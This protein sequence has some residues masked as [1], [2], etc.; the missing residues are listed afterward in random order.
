MNMVPD[1]G[2][3]KEGCEILMEAAIPEIY[4]INAFRISG[5]NV[6]A[7]TREISNQLQ[8][9]RM[10]EKYGNR[11]EITESPLPILPP[12][13]ADQV[14]QALHRLRDPETRIID[15]FFWF[16]PHSLETDQMDHAL[17]LLSRN[18]IKPAESMWLNPEAKLTESNVSKHNLA[19][20]SHLLALDMEQ[21]GQLLPEEEIKMRDKYWKDSF[22]RW[23]SL[24]DHEGIWGRLM[25]R[26]RQMD[27]PRLTTGF[28]KRL[29]E[30]LP[31]SILQINALLALKAAES[32]NEKEA[33]RHLNLINNSG[34]GKEAGSTLKRIV[35]P[36]RNRI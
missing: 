21:N 23:K 33:K 4:R 7:S 27:D 3:L 6:N 32:G 22:K 13:D 1:Q 30:T 14:R 34:F 16:W 17:E 9:N 2:N 18:D 28:V 8:K 29:R 25:A 35:N 20:L 24:L 31:T 36:L 11:T 15:E 26:V 19:I 12:P 10:A 5:L